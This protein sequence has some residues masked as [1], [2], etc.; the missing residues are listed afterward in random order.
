MER[1]S[2][3]YETPTVDPRTGHAATAYISGSKVQG[4]LKYGPADKFHQVLTSV[5]ETLVDPDIILAYNEDEWSGYCYCKLVKTVPTK[6]GTKV[7]RP[8]RFTFAVFVTDTF[9]V[10]EWGLE[11]CDPWGEY[12]AVP[13]NQRGGN[14]GEILWPKP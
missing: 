12:P 13:K 4:L 6:Q 9:K 8:D 5:R 11:P 1:K 3:Y 10:I 7:P 14:M 2:G